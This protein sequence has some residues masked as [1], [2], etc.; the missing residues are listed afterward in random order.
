MCYCWGFLVIGDF[1]YCDEC[2][3]VLFW[4][5]RNFGCEVGCVWLWCCVVVLKLFGSSSWERS[6]VLGWFI[7]FWYRCWRWLL[8][9]LLV[10][11]LWCCVL[12]IVCFVVLGWVLVSVGIVVCFVV[13]WWWLVC[14]N[15][16]WDWE[17]WCV[18][19]VM[20]CWFVGCCRFCGKLCWLVILVECCGV[21]IVCD[22]V[23]DWLCCWCCVICVGCFCGVIGNWCWGVWWFLLLVLVF[24]LVWCWVFFF[25]WCW[26]W[27][28]FC[29][30]EFRCWCWLIWYYVLICCGWFCMF[31]VCILNGWFLVGGVLLKVWW[32][33]CWLYI[34]WCVVCCLGLLFWIGEV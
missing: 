15:R 7:C 28:L 23:V 6:V 27:W 26:G 13:W 25:V 21:F 31:L 32:N 19:W 30:G 34:C 11:F 8:F 2:C 29:L 16:L 4:Y 9:V 1:G 18:G 22:G 12:F 17:C 14:V 10:L 20:L 33:W 24:V 5:F 3:W